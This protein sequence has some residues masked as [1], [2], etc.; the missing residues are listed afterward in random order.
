MRTYL[1]FILLVLASP[2]NAQEIF[3][4]EPR[5]GVEHELAGGQKHIYQFSVT[6]A[7]YVNVIVEQNGI[8]VVLHLIGT[9]GNPIADFDSELRLKGVENVAFIAETAGAYKLEV[10]SKN[11][12]DSLGRYAIRLAEQ[13]TATDRDRSLD[14]AAKL[15]KESD[16][17]VSQDKPSQAR[18]LAERALSIR[19]ELLEPDNPNVASAIN[20]LA[21][22]AYIQEDYANSEA[23]FKRAI[24]I[25]EKSLAPDDPDLSES[26]RGLA[27]VYHM[28]G[29]Y[30]LATAQYQRALEI[31]ERGL[32]PD[33]PEV[34]ALISTIAKHYNYIHDNVHAQLLYQRAL[35]IAEKSYG[36]NHPAYA[37]ALSRVATIHKDLADYGK[38]K[39]MFEQALQI[40]E[41]SYGPADPKIG[42]TLINYGVLCTDM[43]EYEKAESFFQRTL[44]ILEGME[45]DNLA[46]SIVLGNL[47]TTYLADGQYPKA[48]EMFLRALEIRKKLFNEEHPRVAICLRDLGHVYRAEGDYEKAEQY[49]QRA[50]E[51]FKKAYGSDHPELVEPL[52]GLAILYRAKGNISQSIAYQIQANSVI[53]RNISYQLTVGS[54]RQNQIYLTSLLEGVDRT[55]SLQIQSAPDNSDALNMAVNAV[56][57]RK[58]RVLDWMTDSL[59]VVRNRFSTEDQILIDNLNET[60]TQLANLVLNGPQKTSLAAHQGDIRALEEEKEKLEDEISR[61]SAGFYQPADAVSSSTVQAAVPSDAAL[62]EF[63]IYR[64]FDPKVPD[65]KKAYGEPRYVAYIMRPNSEIQWKDLGNVNVIDDAIAAFREGLRNQSGS[66]F[67]K[68]ARTLDEMIMQPIRPML[69]DAAQLL[70]SPDGAL[71]LIPFEAFVDQQ[72]RYLIQ[73]FLCS[74]L[75]SGRDLLRLQFA[76]QSE[77]PAVLIANPLFGQRLLMTTADSTLIAMNKNRRSVTIASDLSK[78]Y[79]APLAGTGEEARAIKTF[80]KEATVYTGKNATETKLK[81]VVAPRILHIATHGFFLTDT[82]A[83]NSSKAVIENPLLRSGLAFAGANER[84]SENDDGIL[85][86]LEASGLNLWGTKLV[87]LSAC[88]TGLGQVQN[89]EGVYGL[90][91]AFFLSGT[92]SLVMS[93]WSVSDYTTRE[94]MTSYYKNLK[95][96]LGRAEALRNVKLKMMQTSRTA[97]PFYWASFIESG[98]WLPL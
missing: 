38:A 32:G 64:P 65:Q 77:T 34:A 8:D 61:R 93:L 26:L 17:L 2:I 85:T 56:L 41:K 33:H 76:R 78:V 86:A 68:I 46:L 27:N 49:Y 63:T 39:P 44:K 25:R 89:G 48:E 36:T 23:L 91:R 90:R 53:E 67:K 29:K 69:G 52:T 55:I 50:V 20:M 73:T 15:I 14:E 75:T 11:K 60:N 37:Q 16:K 94:I 45:P 7:Q 10:E 97:H 57:Q 47:G 72:D 6:R 87:T 12:A 70:I 83:L 98:Q 80:F 84:Q 79:F 71:N 82:P 66:N 13:R 30:S 95:Q 22:I 81:Q 58:A 35:V 5:I 3:S 62:I 24:S 92:E 1:Y 51:V 31:K 4:L 21:K 19:E 43:G 28:Q 88:D 96:G 40:L 18:P 54:E 74:Y 59:A 9:D 42:P